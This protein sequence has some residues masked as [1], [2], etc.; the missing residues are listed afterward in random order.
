MSGLLRP[1]RRIVQLECQGCGGYAFADPDEAPSIVHEGE[2]R[3]IC[4]P[5][6]RAVN[7]ARLAAGLEPLTWG[8]R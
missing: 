5:C 2:R 3:Y 4:P 1:S 7:V 8:T 6:R